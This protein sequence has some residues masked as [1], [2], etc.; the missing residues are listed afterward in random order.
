MN[1]STTLKNIFAA[2]SRSLLTAAAIATGVF[3]VVIIAEISAIGRNGISTALSEMGINSMLVQPAD[4]SSATIDDEVVTTLNNINGVRQAAP[5]MA[6]FTQAKILTDYADCLA[7]G[8]NS[9]A[10]EII[11]LSALHGRLINEADVAANAYVCVI[12]ETIAEQSYGRSNIVGKKI[13][14]LLGGRF[15]EFE[16]VGVAESGISPLQSA[17]SGFIPNF[18]YLPCSTMQRGTGRTTYDKIALLMED[19]APNDIEIII[20]N[21]LSAIEKNNAFTINNLLQQKNQLEN[22]MTVIT[23]ILSLI[24]GISLIVSGITIMTAMLVSV[25]E[26]RR[27]IGIRKSVGAPDFDI[28]FE[29]LT[30]SVCISVFGAVCGISAAIVTAFFACLIMGVNYIFPFNDIVLVLLVAIFFGAVFGAYPAY[31]AAKLP[32]VLALRD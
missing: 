13:N 10:A 6:S 7:W 1:V 29:F 24:A 15:I 27:E 30:E 14:V 23:V 26:R 12:D 25:S 5:L 32:P 11:S 3:A 28:M 31:K 8:I 4:Y 21:R 20:E 18:I 9:N 22:L 17:L 16:V 19:S 2:K